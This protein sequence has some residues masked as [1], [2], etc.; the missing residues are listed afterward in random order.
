ME[1]SLGDAGGGHH[2]SEGSDSAK[3]CTVYESVLPS[4]AVAGIRWL[5]TAIPFLLLETKKDRCCMLSASPE[6]LFARG[7]YRS[8]GVSGVF[9]GQ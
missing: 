2:Q 6:D 7:Q 5:S 9:E 3:R 1:A 4:R 8:E